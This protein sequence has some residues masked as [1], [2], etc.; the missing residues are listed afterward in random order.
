M[1]INCSA[2]WMKQHKRPRRVA[3]YLIE[4]RD[5]I[6]CPGV[7]A[8]INWSRAKT[9]RQNADPNDVM[10]QPENLDGITNRQNRSKLPRKKM[11]VELQAGDLGTRYFTIFKR[12]FIPSETSPVE[13]FH[14]PRRT[15]VIALKPRNNSICGIQESA[16]RL[17]LRPE[18]SS[19]IALRPVQSDRLFNAAPESRH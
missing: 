14:P 4:C 19:P 17:E 16:K 5:Q 13:H 3:T 18:P 1:R 8:Q 6:R 12:L 7:R 11:H 15:T 9:G 2:G 10:R